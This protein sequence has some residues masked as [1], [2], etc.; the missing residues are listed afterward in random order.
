MATRSAIGI[1]RDGG[2]E[3]IYCHWDGYPQHHGHILLNY[4]NQ[5]KTNQLMKHGSLSVLGPNIGVKH[6]FSNPHPWNS[7]AYLAEESLQ[8]N[9]CTFYGRDR[10]DKE[11]ESKIFNDVS[12][13]IDYYRSSGAEYSYLM[14]DGEWYLLHNPEELIPLNKIVPNVKDDLK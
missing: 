6:A 12:E 11:T 3:G 4:Y 5:E 8:E 13:F 14:K 7:A 1:V 2:I 10:G 9:S